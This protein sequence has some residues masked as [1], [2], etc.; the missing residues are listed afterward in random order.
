MKPDL[1]PDVATWVVLAALA[2]VLYV[3]HRMPAPPPRRRSLRRRCSTCE[4]MGVICG[5]NTHHVLASDCRVKEHEIP[6][7]ACR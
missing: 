5:K 2:L 6:C 7:P 4:G 3:L 1:S